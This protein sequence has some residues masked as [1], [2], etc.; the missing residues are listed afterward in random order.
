MSALDVSVQAQIINLLQDIQE[1]FGLAYLFI[2]HDLAVVDHISDRIMVMY[3]GGIMEVGRARD[4][5]GS[6]RHP[7][8]RLL[9]DSVPVLGRERRTEKRFR[10]PQLESAPWTAG[11]EGCPF[12][13]RCPWVEPR[14]LVQK[15]DLVE[16]DAGHHV[17]CHLVH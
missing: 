12:Q 7:Y 17:A 2:A 15:P 5:A 1:Q 10:A 11:S 8:T 9:L 6:P 14:C 13:G 3:L 4:V 16:V